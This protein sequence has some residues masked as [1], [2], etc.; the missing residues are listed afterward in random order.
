MFKKVLFFVVVQLALHEAR[1]Q[2]SAQIRTDT[3]FHNVIKIIP[4]N[5]YVQHVGV[6]CKK[7]WQLQKKTGLNLYIRLGS[8]NYIDYLEQKPNAA[9]LR[10]LPY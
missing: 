4:S 7:E 1:G 2:M 5:Y 6:I 9:A 10:S 8:K 3:S